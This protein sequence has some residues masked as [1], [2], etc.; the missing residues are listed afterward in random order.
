MFPRGLAACTKPVVMVAAR[1]CGLIAA[2]PNASG[3]NNNGCELIDGEPRGVS[4]DHCI[5]LTLH[6]KSVGSSLGS[7][8][9]FRKQESRHEDAI[10]MSRPHFRSQQRSRQGVK[11]AVLRILTHS[12]SSVR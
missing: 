4:W 9:R 8:L 6:S 3:S 7:K 5:F 10:E 11:A 12:G 1:G 2:Q